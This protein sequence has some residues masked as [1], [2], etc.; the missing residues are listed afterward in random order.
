VDGMTLLEEARATG[1]EVKT[2]GDRLIVRGPRSAEGLARILLERK[3]ELIV[4]LKMRDAEVT[5][6]V[7]AMLPQIPENGPVPFLIAREAVEP[8]AGCC[9]SCG[10]LLAGDDR[11]R[12]TPCGR[13][14]NL[15]LE[16]AMSNGESKANSEQ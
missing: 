4:I 10:E 8:Q 1:L 11:Y 12:C 5:W 7:Q 2:E 14:A 15:A 6:R 9:L 3:A 13:A 16:V